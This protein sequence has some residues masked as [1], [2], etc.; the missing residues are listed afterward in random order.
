MW[1][2]L[3]TSPPTSL[4]SAMQ[5]DALKTAREY[6]REARRRIQHMNIASADLDI[7]LGKKQGTLDELLDNGALGSSHRE[8]R[9]R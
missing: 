1:I 9:P 3:L 8:L 5:S 6:E 2:Q 4:R 7:R